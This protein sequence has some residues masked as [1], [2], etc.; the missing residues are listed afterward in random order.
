MRRW[1]II[2]MHTKMTENEA[3]T[4]WCPFARTVIAARGGNGSP[5]QNRVQ[6]AATGKDV[7]LEKCLGAACMAWRQVPNEPF[8]GYCGLA[9]RP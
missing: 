6:E 3:K 5:A 9:G 1:A 7:S 4:K 2:G 8:N